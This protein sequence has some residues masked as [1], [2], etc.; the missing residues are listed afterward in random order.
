MRDQQVT[1]VEQFVHAFDSAWSNNDVE[2][3]VALFAEDATLETPLAQRLL[4]RKDG[5]L[6]GREE[7]RAMVRALMAGG[8]AWGGHEPPLVRGNTLAIEFRRSGSDSEHYSVDI[9]EL[10][11]GKIQTLRAY[12]GWR[13]VPAPADDERR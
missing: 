12:A 7:I 8:K 9:I 2:A 4:H 1:T 5:V 11:E 10:R 6:R 3:A 13:A